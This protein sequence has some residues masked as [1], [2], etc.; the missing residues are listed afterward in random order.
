MDAKNSYMEY[1]GSEEF[2]GCHWQNGWQAGLKACIRVS[3]FLEKVQTVRVP[4]NVWIQIWEMGI[5]EEHLHSFAYAS[6]F[7]GVTSSPLLQL[8]R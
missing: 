2:R 5:E 8:F 4:V 7:E 6:V 1:M 3:S